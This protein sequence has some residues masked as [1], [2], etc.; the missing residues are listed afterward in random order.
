[1]VQSSRRASTTS[2]WQMKRMGFCASGT[3]KAGDEIAFAIVGAEDLDVGGRKAGVE[4]TLGHGFGGDG[5]AADGVGGVDLDELLEDVVG[6]L[7]GPFIEAGL[8][9]RLSLSG[10]QYE[11]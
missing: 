1:M 8:G 4:Q 3:V 5:G 10:W 9:Q 6:E 11:R 7:F 2:V